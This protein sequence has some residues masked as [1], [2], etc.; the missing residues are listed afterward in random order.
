[1]GTPPSP[2]TT[3][4]AQNIGWAKWSFSRSFISA[5]AENPGIARAEALR[6]SM[7]ALM[8]DPDNP[9]FAH[10]LFWAPFV[11]V[12]EGG[13]PMRT[14]A[15]TASLANTKIQPRRQPAIYVTMKN[16]N[17]RARPSTGAARITTLRKGTR[18]TVLGT[19]ADGDW[20]RIA[21]GGKALGYVY[22]PLI[23]P[24]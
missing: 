13:V 10:P 14:A 19:A 20:F 24:R 9:H 23:A 16:A 4:G 1:M 12:G 3:N 22:A 7:L 15:G 6:R 2:T 18:V 11:V 5:S 21:R 17:V 8:N